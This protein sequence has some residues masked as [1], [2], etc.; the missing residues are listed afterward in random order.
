MVAT[1]GQSLPV[2]DLPVSL[3]VNSMSLSVFVVAGLQTLASLRAV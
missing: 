3:T 2:A 1:S